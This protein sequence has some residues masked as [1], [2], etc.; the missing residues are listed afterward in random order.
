[1]AELVD[2]PPQDAG[3]GSEAGIG[4]SLCLE[5]SGCVGEGSVGGVSWRLMCPVPGLATHCQVLVSTSVTLYTT[6]VH[7]YCTP[8][9]TT[10]NRTV[11]RVHY[12]LLVLQLTESR[13]A[14]GRLLLE[15]VFSEG[16]I[17]GQDRYQ[18]RPKDFHSFPVRVKAE[19]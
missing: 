15:R 8:L 11:Y 9:Y 2:T 6:T 17:T 5:E 4:P 14:Q 3:E 10:L 12:T 1:M 19:G 7:H 18:L 16:D 13:S